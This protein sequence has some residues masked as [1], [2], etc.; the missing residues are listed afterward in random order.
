M[1]PP[2]MGSEI[3]VCAE[4]Q[5]V[6]RMTARLRA[7]IE[8]RCSDRA[9]RQFAKVEHASDASVKNCEAV[10]AAAQML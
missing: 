7:V 5:R 2:A 9:E 10:Y 6:D 1:K 4:R 8:S 3:V